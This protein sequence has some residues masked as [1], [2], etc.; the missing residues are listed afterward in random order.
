MPHLVTS[1]VFFVEFAEYLGSIVVSADPLIVGD[2]NIHIDSNE[3]YDAIMCRVLAWLNIFKSLHIQI[4]DFLNAQKLYPQGQSAYRE[5]HSAETALLR[6]TND[7]MM[8]MNCQHVTLLVSSAFEFYSGL[9]RILVKVPNLFQSI[10]ADLDFF[11]Y[12]VESLEVLV[13]GPYYL[14]CVLVNC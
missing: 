5:Y 9:L 12:H 13:W 7:V 6:V 14:Y 8:N 11:M 3:N 10:V 2:F 1:A 4:N